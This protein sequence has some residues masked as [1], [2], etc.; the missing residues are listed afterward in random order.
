MRTVRQICG[1]CG[2]PKG[3]GAHRIWCSLFLA[4][5]PVAGPHMVCSVCGFIPSPWCCETW[6][7]KLE[8]IGQRARAEKIRAAAMA[9]D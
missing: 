6:A 5:G 2:A 9:E 3:A 8:S 4:E 1:N 7:K